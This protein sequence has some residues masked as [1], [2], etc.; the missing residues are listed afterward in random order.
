MDVRDRGPEAQ[1][2]APATLMVDGRV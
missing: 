1:F 2:D